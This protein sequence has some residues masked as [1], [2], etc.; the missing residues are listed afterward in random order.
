M[1]FF[2]SDS[3]L[4]DEF[5]LKS[6]LRPFKNVKQ[7]DKY[8]IRTW[9]KQAKKDDEIFVVGDFIDCDGKESVEWK[10]SIF[11][12]KKIKAKVTL[13]MGNN[14][15]RIVKYFFNNNFEEFRS[16]CVKLGFKDVIK[17][18][19]LTMRGKEFYLV[20]KPAEY[21]ENY[22][23]LVGHSHAAGGIYKPFGLNVG[24]DLFHFR[25]VSEDDLF[26]LLRKKEK[27][28]DKDKH[29]NM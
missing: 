28:W 6:D 12:V 29:L 20:H 10:K 26:H 9:N 7:F 25:L 13:V 8:V 27:Y 17:N 5:T 18:M 15:D 11:L 21:K 16:F 14:E 23:N 2:T 19:T 1:R 22:I 4:G 24:C 3:H